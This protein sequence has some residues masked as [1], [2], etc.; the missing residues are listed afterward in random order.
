MTLFLPRRLHTRPRAIEI[1]YHRS[2]QQ[3]IRPLGWHIQGRRLI[4]PPW[5]LAGNSSG[6]LN[7]DLDRSPWCLSLM[8]V[9]I[10]NRCLLPLP[11]EDCMDLDLPLRAGRIT[12]MRSR[13]IDR[14]LQGRLTS[15][16]S[17]RHP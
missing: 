11:R 8:Q 15:N 9:H 17:H 16:P 6:I 2:M 1:V 4:K 12:P 5:S 7:T 10:K 13:Y 3:Q 14:G